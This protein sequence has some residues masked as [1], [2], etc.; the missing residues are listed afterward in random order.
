MMSE[1]SSSYRYFISC[2]SLESH[3]NLLSIVS[4]PTATTEKSLE[5][6]YSN[7]PMEE[8]LERPLSDKALENTLSSYRFL[9]CCDSWES[10]ESLSTILSFSN[11]RTEKRSQDLFSE[12]TTEKY[13]SSCCYFLC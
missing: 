12:T 3:E 4:F 6:T 10:D 8:G 9:L 1:D 11:I 13:L 2:E 7:E 5:V